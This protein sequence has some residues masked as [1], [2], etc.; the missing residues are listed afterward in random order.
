MRTMKKLKRHAVTALGMIGGEKVMPSLLESLFNDKIKN[1]RCI[2]EAIAGLGV[3]IALPKL[4]ELLK[5]KSCL[6]INY[7][8]TAIGALKSELGVKPIIDYMASYPGIYSEETVKVRNNQWTFSVRRAIWAIRSE[9]KSLKIL[10]IN[11]LG[12]MKAHAILPTLVDFLKDQDE[13]IVANSIIAIGKIGDS[14]II[15]NLEISMKTEHMKIRRAVAIAFGDIGDRRVTHP[16]IFLLND[17][18]KEVRTSAIDS[19]GKL[20][21][22][23]AVTP[24][25][26]VLTKE[27]DYDVRIALVRAL[28][29][30]GN[31]VVVP[32]L[33]AILDNSEQVV[34]GKNYQNQALFGNPTLIWKET[35]TALGKIGSFTALERLLKLFSDFVPPATEKWIESADCR[36]ELV[37]TLG[38]IGDSSVVDPLTALIKTPIPTFHGYFADFRSRYESRVRIAAR[39][40]LMK[41]TEREDRI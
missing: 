11:A 38:I 28:G 33:L 5:E 18:V 17:S 2:Y 1:K 10:A 15:E 40:A 39:E 27:Q 6:K 16:L 7:V 24:L 25:L 13:D 31:A 21:S 20:K 8:I 36:L 9:D 23:I 4:V 32:N 41:V 19:L 22:G 14:S 12:R 3:E 29:E 26:R 37:H 30:I 35:I 34:I